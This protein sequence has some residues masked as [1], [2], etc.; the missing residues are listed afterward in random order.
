LALHKTAHHEQSYP[1]GHITNLEPP[2]LPIAEKEKMSLRKRF[3][4]ESKKT[5]PAQRPMTAGGRIGSS[6]WGTGR[7]EE[8]NTVKCV[9]GGNGIEGLSMKEKMALME[10]P[11]TGKVD[12]VML[13]HAIESRFVLF[14]TSI[15]SNT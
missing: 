3:F 11:M 13:L 6:S 2:V 15:Q 14:L 12:L 5:P 10:D 7:K 8:V 4:S 1:N 9:G